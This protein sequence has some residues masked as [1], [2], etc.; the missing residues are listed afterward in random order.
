MG[1]L[2]H[3]NIE[4]CYQL[5]NTA[6][7]AAAGAGTTNQ[8]PAVIQCGLADR[9]TMF[10]VQLLISLMLT[11]HPN[12]L[13]FKCGIRVAVCLYVMCAPPVL[14]PPPPTL[15]TPPRTHVPPGPKGEGGLDDATGASGAAG[16]A[17]YKQTSRATQLSEC[18]ATGCV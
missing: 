1:G 15:P 9:Q 4:A 5:D 6:A 10:F 2:C 17:S 18:A 13:S 8:Q 12:D 14:R 7:R 11:S 16:G 3:A